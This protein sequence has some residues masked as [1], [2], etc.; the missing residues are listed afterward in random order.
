MTVIKFFMTLIKIKNIISDLRVIKVFSCF[1]FC[2]RTQNACSIGLV[3]H[4]I[5]SCYLFS[6]LVNLISL[7]FFKFFLLIFMLFKIIIIVCT[8]AENTIKLRVLVVSWKHK[9]SWAQMTM[10]SSITIHAL[11]TCPRLQT[12][13]TLKSSLVY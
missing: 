9:H 6:Y 5:V 4:E 7:Q 12:S 11:D 2:F 8:F 13:I 3:F 10:E 1:I